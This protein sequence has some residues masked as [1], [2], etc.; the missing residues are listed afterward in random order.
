MKTAG[1]YKKIFAIIEYHANV[2]NQY[3]ESY[4]IQNWLYDS[5]FL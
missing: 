5:L 4:N 1:I 2:G 3:A